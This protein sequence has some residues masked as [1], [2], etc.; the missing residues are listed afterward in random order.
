MLLVGKAVVRFGLAPAAS[1]RQ[2]SLNLP[3]PCL[4]STVAQNPR[5]YSQFLTRILWSP[6]T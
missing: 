5:P 4:K 2:S 6:G 3:A 1:V